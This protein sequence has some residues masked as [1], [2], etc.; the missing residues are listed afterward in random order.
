MDFSEVTLDLC[1]CKWGQLLI[2]DGVITKVKSFQLRKTDV[3]GTR[4]AT[5]NRPVYRAA[6][7]N[8]ADQPL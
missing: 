3:S 1:I 4:R 7:D 5:S 8:H 2:S 6:T